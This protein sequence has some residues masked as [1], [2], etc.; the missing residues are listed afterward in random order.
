MIFYT[1]RDM[2][3]TRT[4]RARQEIRE[5]LF[6]VIEAKLIKA[7]DM[8]LPVQ[9]LLRPNN[10][11][12]KALNYLIKEGYLQLHE[13]DDEDEDEAISFITT[14]KLE[15]KLPAILVA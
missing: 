12:K 5:K 2:P 4:Q 8:K 7:G 1:Q 15:A 11:Q 14:P 13:E 6:K 9:C 10:V 3:L